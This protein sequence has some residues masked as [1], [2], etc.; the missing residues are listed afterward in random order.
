MTD[1]L[2]E[3][4]RRA[5]A[6]YEQDPQPGEQYSNM[7]RAAIRAAAPHILDMAADEAAS[8]RNEVAAARNI[9]SL[10]EHFQ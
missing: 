9:N 6:L 5:L 8:S 4:V 3:V 2:V 7:A 1:N 10:K